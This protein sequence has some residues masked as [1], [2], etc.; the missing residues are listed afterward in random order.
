MNWTED[1]VLRTVVSILV[2]TALVA[3]VFYM[4]FVDHKDSGIAVG[5]LISIAT[6]VSKRLFDSS[7]SSERKT[8]LL[9]RADPVDTTDRQ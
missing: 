6:L 4:L 8:E 9:A 5:A 1:K 7:P 2:M 3:M